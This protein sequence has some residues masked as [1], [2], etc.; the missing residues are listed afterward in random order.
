MWS[1]LSTFFIDWRWPLETADYH[2]A[3]FLCWVEQHPTHRGNTRS[4]AP[5]DQRHFH[6]KIPI[7]IGIGW[8][9]LIRE[10]R[11]GHNVK[12]WSAKIKGTIR[13]DPAQCVLLM[14]P[15]SGYKHLRSLGPA[16]P[17]WQHQ[18][19]CRGIPR[20]KHWKNTACIW[21]SHE[22]CMGRTLGLS[23]QN[24]KKDESCTV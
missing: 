16:P 3:F 24:K 7:G 5:W 1:I 12:Q 11:R 19:A 18:S 17:S 14:Y 6:D 21:A 23:L 22:H 4:Y 2:E 9:T 13:A 15:T 10:R 20:T 8:A